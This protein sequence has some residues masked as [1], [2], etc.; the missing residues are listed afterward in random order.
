M[1]KVIELLPKVKHILDEHDSLAKPISVRGIETLNI[2]ETLE[3][4]VLYD[5]ESYSLFGTDCCGGLAYFGLTKDIED[6]QRQAEK[7]L[8]FF[9]IAQ[10]DDE[11]KFYFLWTIGDYSLLILY[12]NYQDEVDNPYPTNS[13]V[14]LTKFGSW[15]S[16]YP[17]GYILG[18]SKEEHKSHGND[19][20]VGKKDFSENNSSHALLL[21]QAKELIKKIYPFDCEDYN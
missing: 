6:I 14:L 1:G 7:Y 4:E 19:F 15:I 9:N 12:E 5:P 13:N 11:S 8:D 16:D 21:N 3:F 2:V 17:L 10:D 20:L 18:L